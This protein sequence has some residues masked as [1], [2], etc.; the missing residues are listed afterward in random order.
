MP[1]R[2]FANDSMTPEPIAVRR[3]KYDDEIPTDRTE[4]TNTTPEMSDGL[5][6][7]RHYSEDW[8]GGF[9]AYGVSVKDQGKTPTR[10]QVSVNPNS[11][12]RGGE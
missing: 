2:Q 12:K 9:D 5:Y 7:G 8:M 4:H 11:A 3:D 1:G 10:E 6:I